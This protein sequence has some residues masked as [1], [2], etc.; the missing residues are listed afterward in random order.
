LTKNEI[1]TIVTDNRLKDDINLSIASLQGHE[2]QCPP[3]Y[4]EN[5]CL[6]N[7][8]CKIL[9]R[10]RTQN[11]LD[12]SCQCKEIY[13]GTRCQFKQAEFEVTPPQIRLRRGLNRFKKSPNFQKRKCIIKILKLL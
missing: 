1:G 5:Y 10:E 6:H 9:L 2:F 12:Y 13:I 8:T 3:Q 4:A 11:I 7:G